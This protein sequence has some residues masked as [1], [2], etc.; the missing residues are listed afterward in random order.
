[1]GLWARHESSACYIHSKHGIT[2]KFIPCLLSTVTD[3]RILNI[4][5]TYILTSTEKRSTYGVPQAECNVKGLFKYLMGAL[6][7]NT[8]SLP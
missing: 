8:V 3:H 7:Q 5:R 4:V 1:M 2:A 6:L